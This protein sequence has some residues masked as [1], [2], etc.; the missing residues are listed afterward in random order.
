MV[1][2]AATNQPLLFG[3]SRLIGT[4][5]GYLDMGR[6]HLDQAAPDHHPV[7]RPHLRVDGRLRRSY[8]EGAAVRQEH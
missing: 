1:Y 3:G 7:Q 4:G 6:R 2:D 8:P 5:G